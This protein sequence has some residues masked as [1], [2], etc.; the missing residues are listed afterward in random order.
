[1]IAN[2]KYKW[3][4]WTAIVG[5]QHFLVKRGDRVRLI[6]Q[7]GLLGQINGQIA[8]ID[9][10]SR[11]V[12]VDDSCT[13]EA[14]KSY[15]LVTVN[16]YGH[17]YTWTATGNGTTRQLNIVESIDSSKIAVD[18]IFG[19]GEQGKNGEE[20]E[21]VEKQILNEY[22]ARLILTPYRGVE[23]DNASNNIPP[24]QTKVSL[25]PTRNYIGPLPPRV[26]PPISDEGAL[27]KDISGKVLP[28]MK[29]KI[30]QQTAATRKKGITPAVYFIVGYKRQDENSWRELRFDVNSDQIIIPGLDARVTYNIRVQSE[31]AKGRRSGYVETSHTVIGLSAPPPDVT[32]LEVDNIEGQAFLRWEYPDPP[33][34]LS[35]FKVRY[36][37]D[38]SATYEN[39]IDFETVFA[40]NTRFAVVEPI[41]G[42][43]AIKAVDYNGNLSV[44]AIYAE[45][46][47]IVGSEVDDVETLTESTTYPGTKLNVDTSSGLLLLKSQ[48]RSATSPLMSDW[49]VLAD[50]GFMS[51]P[52]RTEY[53]LEG[54]YT[55]REV[56]IGAV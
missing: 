36:S 3:Q 33:Q 4:R 9:Y 28:A 52:A 46:T 45:S 37:T 21:V 26:F 29:L 39:M 51:T 15:E 53:F 13:F 16:Q 41:D 1:M 7:N 48:A 10:N 50:L 47:P 2:E 17:V 43:Y 8:D 24:F 34:D 35:H 54:Y 44:N 23:I 27:P 30:I 20:C 31:D 49:P 12:T 40:E 19:F 5:P 18:D 38:K 6:N 56:D 42:Q 14:G 11:I 32:K 55:T 22:Q 25:P